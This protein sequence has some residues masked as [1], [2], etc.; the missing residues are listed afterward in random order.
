[1][2]LTV[3]MIESQQKFRYEENKASIERLHA[4]ESGDTV[5]LEFPDGTVEIVNAVN[6]SVFPDFRTT[7]EHL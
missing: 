3:K 7:F 5:L 1:M 4:I 2:L 6:K